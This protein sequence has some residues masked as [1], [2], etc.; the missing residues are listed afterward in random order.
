M[1]RTALLAAFLSTLATPAYSHP[2]LPEGHVHGFEALAMA[3]AAPYILGFM[4]AALLVYF[5]RKAAK[6]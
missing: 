3:D 4:A 2:A 1:K 5:V 6:I